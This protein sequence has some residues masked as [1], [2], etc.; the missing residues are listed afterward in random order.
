MKGPQKIILFYLAPHL[1][2][3]KREVWSSGEKWHEE[4]LSRYE[5]K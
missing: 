4:A 1:G 2:I 5:Q 3:I